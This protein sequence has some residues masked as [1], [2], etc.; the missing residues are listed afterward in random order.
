MDYQGFKVGQISRRMVSKRRFE[1]EKKQNDFPRS[2][3]GRT[4]SYLDT[5]SN[6]LYYSVEGSFNAGW[7]CQVAF[8]LGRYA[9][10]A[11]LCSDFATASNEEY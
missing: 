9:E 8:S 4:S 10:V 11:G 2:T 1:E 5:T 3:K 6:I 7:A